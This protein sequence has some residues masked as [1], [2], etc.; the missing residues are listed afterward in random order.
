MMKKIRQLITIYVSIIFIAVSCH[1]LAFAT[2]I[3]DT[4]QT[5]C[6]NNTVEITCP[7][8]GQ[9]FYGQDAQ[10]LINPQSYTKLDETG[11]ELPDTASDWAMIRDNV[12]G[13]IWERKNNY[14]DSTADYSNPHDVD[15]LYNWYDS[16]PA[17]NGGYA[18]TTNYF[19]ST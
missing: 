12:T 11:Y 1:G 7:Q 2:S 4:G 17:T 6:Y 3:P 5:K 16:N 9:P 14:N 15:N 13:L 8:P 18:G 19:D 10:Y